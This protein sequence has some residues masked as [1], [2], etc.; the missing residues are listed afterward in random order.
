MFDLSDEFSIRSTVFAASGVNNFIKCTQEK[1][2]TSLGIKGELSKATP[3][4]VRPSYRVI[5]AGCH[6]ADM[7]RS[8]ELLVLTEGAKWLRLGE[9]QEFKKRVRQSS[10][11]AHTNSIQ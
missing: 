11:D 2:L 1:F 6:P 9:I 7:S 10:P 8:D 5:S 3:A 4:I